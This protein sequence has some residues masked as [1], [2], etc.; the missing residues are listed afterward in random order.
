MKDLLDLQQARIEALQNELE[1][2]QKA[3]LDSRNLLAEFLEEM[4]KIQI[5]LNN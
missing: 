3:L 2:T 4:E 5:T 1:K